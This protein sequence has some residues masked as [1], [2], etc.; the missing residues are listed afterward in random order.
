MSIA[1]PARALDSW[2]DYR[3]ALL[4]ALARSASGVRLLDPDLAATGLESAAGVAALQEFVRR[5]AL[6]EA[7]RILLADTRFLER[8]APRLRHLL[9]RF[10]HRI[11]VRRIA[12]RDQT[13]ADTPV[14][15]GDDHILVTR[16][17]RDRPRGRFAT[18]DSVDCAPLAAQ[19]ETIW[20]TAENVQS[21]ARLGL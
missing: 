2:T 21:G 12:R 19:F 18:A 6:P 9:E 17:H 20:V 1:E 15:I 11:A 7:V 3:A 8:D 10:G 13:M 14:L 16:F 5:S 4:D